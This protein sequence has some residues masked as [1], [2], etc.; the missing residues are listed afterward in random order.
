M[1]SV[2][3]SGFT[4]IKPS[5]GPLV[6]AGTV[7]GGL[8]TLSVYGYKVTYVTGFGETDPSP[9]ST[10]TTTATGSVLVQSIPISTNGNVIARKLYRTVA[11]GANYLLLAV[12]NDNYT[13]TYSDTAVDGLL[14]SA[15]P[16]VN[17]ASSVQ[18]VEGVFKFNKPSIHSIERNITAGA[19]AGGT[20][21]AYQL[22]AEY[23]WVSTAAT[24]DGV[25][26]PA[27]AA[28]LVGSYVSIRNTSANTIRIFPF[29]GQTVNSGLV[30]APAT[31]ATLTSAVFIADTATN[32]SLT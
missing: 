18:N 17:L 29:D 28:A 13:T 22:T 3:N 8:S 31:L 19:S 16:K 23:S 15:A 30:D 24:N 5:A 14:S 2:V 12:I 9:A 20:A 26:L 25:K 21:A 1:S 7:A 11:G 27:T 4:I 32:W 10:L 6:V